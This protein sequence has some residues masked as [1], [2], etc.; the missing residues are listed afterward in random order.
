[1]PELDM[2]RED[3]LTRLTLNRAA[4]ANALSGDLVDALLSAVEAAYHD[5][6]RLLV[7]QG[8]GEH[9]CAGFDFTG[10]EHMSEGDLALRFVR[11]E[12]LMEALYRLPGLGFGV[13]LGT[14][15]LAQRTGGDAARAVLASSRAFDAKDAE[16]IGFIQKISDADAWPAVIQ[17]ALA[18]A[19]TLSPEAAAAL[20]RQTT[21]DTRADDMAALARS[22]ATPGLKQRIAHYRNAS[23]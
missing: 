23:N 8:D 19:Q 3:A 2:A 13:V 9:F 21:P 14:Q 18:E 1:M 6:T 22:V 16:A 20:Y 5:G 4:K 11:I 7:L 10:F 15:R 17:A 12:M